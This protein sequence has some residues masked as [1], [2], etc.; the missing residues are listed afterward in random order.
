MINLTMNVNSNIN[1]AMTANITH[2]L[3]YHGMASIH[4]KTGLVGGL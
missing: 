4:R 3:K 1:N 2:P